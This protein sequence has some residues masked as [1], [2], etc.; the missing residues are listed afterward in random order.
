MTWDVIDEGW[1]NLLEL[2]RKYHP[3]YTKPYKVSET[4]MLA[5]HACEV[6]RNEIRESIHTTVG[7]IQQMIYARQIEDMRILKN[8]CSEIWFG[9]PE[10]PSIRA[11]PGFFL[12]CD[13]CD[14][15]EE[16]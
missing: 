11:Q 16:E 12:L 6:V 8:I 14:E 4:A 15:Y 2:C 9:M 10:T 5:E 1:G 3:A 7:P 13:I